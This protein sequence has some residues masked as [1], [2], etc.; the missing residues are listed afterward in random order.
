M[1]EEQDKVTGKQI[2]DYRKKRGLS[3]QD[4]AT[5]M[6]VS[7]PTIKRWESEDTTPRDRHLVALAAILGGTASAAA[8]GSSLV[9][10][11]LGIASAFGSSLALGPIGPLLLGLGAAV[12]G[13]VANRSSSKAH[14]VSPSIP[15]AEQA[16]QQLA[17]LREQVILQLPVPLTVEDRA[18]AEKVRLEVN[19][20]RVLFDKFQEEASMRGFTPSR[21]LESLLWMF[22]EM[23]PLSFQEKRACSENSSPGQSSSK[24]D[25]VEAE[26]RP[27]NYQ[28]TL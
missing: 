25:S 22:M 12:A 23:P 26:A 6:G 15:N 1:T 2:H 3:Q 4:L 28:H 5:M 18:K 20:D 7:L 14:P 8:M 13:F 21:F 10:T 27:R 11:G 9:P 24:E 17:Q 16:I 19:I